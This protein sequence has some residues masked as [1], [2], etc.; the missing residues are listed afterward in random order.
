MKR[1]SRYRQMRMFV[2][3]DLPNT[4]K[5]DTKNYTKF[6]K[7]LIK[8]VYYMIQYSIYCKLCINYDEVNKNNNRI[9]LHKPPK[10]NVRILIVT[11]KQYESIKILVGNK[12]NQEKY[13]TTRTVVE[14]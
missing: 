3:Y 1:E 2:F 4:T 5:M 12:S 11:E 10:G 8:N 7:F 13:M 14:L 6:H 9:D